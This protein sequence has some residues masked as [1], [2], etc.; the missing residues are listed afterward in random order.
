MHCGVGLHCANFWKRQLP[1]NGLQM[2]CVHGSP[3]PQSASALHEAP[4]PLIFWYE[5]MPAC[6][7]QLSLVHAFLS[8][9]TS[10]LPTH[11]PLA[12]VSAL[13]HALPSSHVPPL[14]GTVEQT[15]AT[16]LSVV[17]A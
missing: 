5:H 12:H 16:Q 2:S 11:A 14:M 7:S 6:L 15:L 4:Q 9:H 8:S 17:H 10:A 3:S 13:V 1:V